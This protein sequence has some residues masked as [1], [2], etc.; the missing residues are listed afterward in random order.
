VYKR[1]GSIVAAVAIVVGRFAGMSPTQAWWLMLPAAAGVVLGA[2][3]GRSAVADPYAIA[4]RIDTQLDLKDRL[5]GGYDLLRRVR[6]GDAPPPTPFTAL[7]LADAAAAAEEAAGALRMPLRLPRG[8]PTGVLCLALAAALS[9]LALPGA[10]E[11]DGSRPISREQRAQVQALSDLVD[12]I[13]AL[14]GLDEEQKQALV[15]ALGNI[16]FD[17]DELQKM[18]RADIIRR[19]KEAGAKIPEGVARA[20]VRRAIEDKVRA[21]AE[22]EQIEQQLA[23]IEAINRREARID[24]GD[25][26]TTSA[27]N[28]KLESSDLK[29]DQAIAAAAARPGEGER[30]YQR[31]VAAAEARARAEREKIRKFLARTLAK[32]LPATDA[33]KLTALLASDAEFQE[34]VMAAIRDPDSKQFDVMREIYRRQLER[35]FERENIP[36]GLRQQLST[37]LGR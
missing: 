32:D 36:R 1:Q 29:I 31:R 37:Y 15:E 30:E 18:S 35:E 27:V 24:L 8:L 20:A 2:F 4:K 23:E 28:I 17:E 22:Q 25:G 19:L 5:A 12:T 10:T 7:V 13:K 26:R 21:I 11:T 6:S 33:Q 14:E 3:I 16:Q 34:K 9:L